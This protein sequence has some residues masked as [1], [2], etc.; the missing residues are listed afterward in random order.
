M[1]WKRESWIVVVS[2]QL[3]QFM[4]S[5][6][7]S[8]N[9]RAR[10]AR[11]GHAW[12]ACC[13]GGG[14]GGGGYSRGRGDWPDEHAGKLGVGECRA[15]DGHDVEHTEQRRGWH[16]RPHRAGCDQWLLSPQQTPT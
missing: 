5:W 15:R 11:A 7:C 2:R 12:G 6:V 9:H 14:G 8:I 13:M 4:R 1:R 10:R 3:S 16:G